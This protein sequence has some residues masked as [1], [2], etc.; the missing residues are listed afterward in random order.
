MHSERTYK[1]FTVVKYGDYGQDLLSF[2]FRTLIEENREFINLLVSLNR[3][4]FLR[5]IFD[6]EAKLGSNKTKLKVGSKIS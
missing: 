1:I 2:R 6:I 5:L 3:V 4:I